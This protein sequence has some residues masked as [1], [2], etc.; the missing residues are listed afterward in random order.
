MH[1]KSKDRMVG[2]LS[3]IWTGILWGLLL[4]YSA[5]RGHDGNAGL[6]EEGEFYDKE[7]CSHQ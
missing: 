2:F 3:A 1:S 6:K 5:M 4:A 7:N